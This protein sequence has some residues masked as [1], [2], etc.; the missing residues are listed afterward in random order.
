MINLGILGCSEIAFR[1]FMPAVKNVEGIVV[2]AVAEEYDPNKLKTFS[3]TYGLETADSF[4]EL[5]DREDID[6]VYVPQPPALHF[7]WAKYAL[8][9][10]KHVLIEKPS[11]MEYKTSEELV[12]LAESKCLAL[13]ENYMF[14]YHSQIKDIQDLIESGR[15]GEVRLIRADFGFPMRMQNDFR[16]NATLGGGALLDAGG[17]TTKL[18]T[19]LLGNSIKVDAASV[20]MMDGFEVDMYGSASFSN[21]EG[22]VCQIGFGMDCAYRCSLEVWGSKA[23]LFTNRI[24]TAPPE[25]EPVVQLESNAGTEEIKLSV[26]GHFEHSIEMFVKAVSD[27]SLRERLYGEILLQSKL[28]DEIRDIG[29]N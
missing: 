20:N 13:H 23:K 17:Y 1:R 21:D 18:A 19:L 12:K 6:A 3:E 5:I 26:D 4:G 27:N 11:T 22:T 25:F 10:G 28:I 9:K 29:K 8:E 7:K 15:I 16:Y 2:K 24:F 14:Q